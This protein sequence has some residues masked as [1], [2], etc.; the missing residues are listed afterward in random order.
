MPNQTVYEPDQQEQHDLNVR[1]DI[2][3]AQ[4]E[5]ISPRVA[6]LTDYRTVCAPYVEEVRE[7]L[8]GVRYRTKVNFQGTAF[9]FY[10]GCLM[11]QAR[12]EDRLYAMPPFGLDK[13]G[14]PYVQVLPEHQ[15][16]WMDEFLSLPKTVLLFYFSLM[17]EVFRGY[18]LQGRLED[19][20]TGKISYGSIPAALAPILTEVGWGLQD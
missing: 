11:V 3:V 7:V 4:A 18:R 5:V 20:A 16:A 2:E 17:K 1:P 10:H 14:L 9:H 8:K 13:N 15:A 19:P 12:H 6:L